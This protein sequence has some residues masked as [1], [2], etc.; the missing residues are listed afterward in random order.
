ML[1]DTGVGLHVMAV[2]FAAAA[3]IPLLGRTRAHKAEQDSNAIDF[4]HLRHWRHEQLNE[5]LSRL[6]PDDQ[7]EQLS[8]Q[9]VALSRRSWRKHRNLQF[10]ML[11]A[12]LGSAL[13][14]IAVLIPR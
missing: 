4:G 5:R 1:A 11:A 7:L 12:L 3:V 2:T 10:S 14:G 13:I 8:R 9:L 6:S